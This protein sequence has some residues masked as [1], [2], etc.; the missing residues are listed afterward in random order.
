MTRVPDLWG[1]LTASRNNPVAWTK[2]A[3]GKL[4]QGDVSRAKAILEVV[5]EH[6]PAKQPAEADLLLVQSCILSGPD[7]MSEAIAVAR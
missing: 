4:G 6:D 1:Q 7:Y 3:E 5:K 2:I